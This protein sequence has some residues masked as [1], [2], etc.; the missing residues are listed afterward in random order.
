MAYD[1]SEG[2]RAEFQAAFD[3]FDKNGDK[4]ISAKEL[5]VVMQGIG[6]H[7]TQ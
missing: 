1:F 4:A 3:F 7:I 5:G 2:E 6:Q